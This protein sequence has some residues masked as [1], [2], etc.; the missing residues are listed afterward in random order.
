MYIYLSCSNCGKRRRLSNKKVQYT[1]NAIK[2]G[3]NSYD[4]ALYCPE[5][6]RTWHD[7][8]TKPMAGEKNTFIVIMNQ[9]LQEKEATRERRKEDAAGR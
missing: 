8:N 7:R 2:Q 5:C 9:I 1:V 6:S 3:W 4:V